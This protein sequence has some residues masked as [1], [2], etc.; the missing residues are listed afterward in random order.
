MNP[1]VLS[2]NLDSVAADEDGRANLGG[3]GAINRIIN[4]NN[5]NDH[6]RGEEADI[7]KG[8][9]KESVIM[10]DEEDQ[11]KQVLS[12]LGLLGLSELLGGLTFS[13]LSPF[14]TKEATQKGISVTETGIV[15]TFEVCTLFR[16]QF[17][18]CRIPHERSEGMTGTKNATH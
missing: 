1:V 6:G 2:D 5:N 13:L 8:M 15:S 16:C 4:N 9:K 10:A 3:G 14:Y 18:L 17:P 12:N 11:R 7:W